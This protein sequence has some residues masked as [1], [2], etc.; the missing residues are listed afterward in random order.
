MVKEESTVKERKKYQKSEHIPT[1]TI[2]WTSVRANQ[3]VMVQK[4]LGI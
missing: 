1:A 4:H 2:N 3:V